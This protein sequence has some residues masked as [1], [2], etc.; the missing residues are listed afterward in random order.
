MGLA[1][2]VLI[3]LALANAVL[4]MTVLQFNWSRWWLFPASFALLAL[5]GAISVTSAQN[6]LNQRKRAND[7]LPGA[8]P[9][10]PTNGQGSQAA[11]VEMAS[12]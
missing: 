1:W 5:S 4:V 12:H 10:S 6:E 2:K 7:R 3:P 8:G 11:H 9:T